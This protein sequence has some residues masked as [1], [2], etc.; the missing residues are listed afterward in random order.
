MSMGN[1][2]RAR[3]VLNPA[4][5]VRHA[6]IGLDHPT[7]VPANFDPADPAADEGVESRKG[8]DHLD[9]STPSTGSK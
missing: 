7:T 5:A 4:M 1:Y 8:E 3:D 2:L 6:P 9:E